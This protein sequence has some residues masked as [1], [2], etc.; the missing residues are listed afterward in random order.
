MSTTGSVI[1]KSIVGTIVSANIGI[2]CWTVQTVVE[3][4]KIIAVNTSV[5]RGNSDELKDIQQNG[6]KA[7]RAHVAEDDD[8][9]RTVREDIRD[10][11][12][13]M[14]SMQSVVSDMG[15]VK[16]RLDALTKGQDR[17]EALL[18]D[19]ITKPNPTK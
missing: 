18:T 15:V 2:L 19:G 6:S 5:L 11:K 13:S 4:G 12:N 14:L 16:S 1:W 3:H 10:L 9:V 8:R 7:L 17:I